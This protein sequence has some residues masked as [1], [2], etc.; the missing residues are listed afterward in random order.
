MPFVDPPRRESLFEAQVPRV[1]GDTR[2]LSIYSTNENPNVCMAA[3]KL[4]HQ[5]NK[6]NA[7]CRLVR[8]RALGVQPM[9]SDSGPRAAHSMIF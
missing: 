7:G 2:G 8:A 4:T 6:D 1:P 3:K 9:V 5:M